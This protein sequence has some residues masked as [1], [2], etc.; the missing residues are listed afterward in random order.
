MRICPLNVVLSKR[1]SNH[2]L[3]DLNYICKWC[4]YTHVCV[5]V[6][7]YM[8]VYVYVCVFWCVEKPLSKVFADL[9]RL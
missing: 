9:K 6:G 2:K 5:Y 8:C 4:L 7:V 3:I 1:Q